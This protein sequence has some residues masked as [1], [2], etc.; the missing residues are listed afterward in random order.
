MQP[1]TSGLKMGGAAGDTLAPMGWGLSG[2]QEAEKEVCLGRSLRDFA[3]VDLLSLPT[4]P[5]VHPSELPG[6]L[7]SPRELLQPQP[8]P[9]K[10][11]SLG[12][13][14]GY[15]QFAKYFRW[16]CCA[17]SRTIA[18]MPEDHNGM[19]SLRAFTFF[20]SFRPYE[21]HRIIQQHTTQNAITQHA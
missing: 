7:E 2:A 10:P 15:Q 17:A 13:S 14:P 5:W 4:R 21:R 18:K 19:A 3:S 1:V 11:D 9:I 6:P 20:L 16:F 12:T 8:R